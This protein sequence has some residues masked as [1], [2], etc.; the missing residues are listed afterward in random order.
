MK[1][2]R[3][4]WNN[5]VLS[6]FLS[7][8][9]ALLP[10]VITVAIVAWVAGI[11]S[12]I[13]GP[14]AF[15]GHALRAVGLKFVDNPTFA[16]VIGLL[17]VLV[18][19]WV[20]GLFTKWIAR[21]QVESLLKGTV[22]RIPV[23]NSVYGTVVQFVNLLKRDKDSELSG[24][25]VVFCTFGSDQQCGFLALLATAERYRIRDRDYC[26][27]YIPTS[28][29]PMSGAVIFVPADQVHTIDMNAE[30]LMRIYLTMGVAAPTTMPAASKRPSK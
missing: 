3:W 26:V 18:V 8:L 13:L 12:S 16:A 30:Q 25:S 29:L 27:V 1:V 5:G 10:L 24:M 2:L 14:D 22:D 7:G 21:N 20:V 9:F 17:L 15:L 11:L 6:T 19:V 4:V 28:P 23:V